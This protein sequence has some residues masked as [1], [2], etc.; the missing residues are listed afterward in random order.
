MSLLVLGLPWPGASSPPLQDGVTTAPPAD[1][2]AAVDLLRGLTADTVLVVP[3]Q[4]GPAASRRLHRARKLVGRTDVAV[5]ERRRPISRLAMAARLVT[6]AQAFWPAEQSEAMA[7]VDACLRTTAL[8]HSVGRLEDPAPSLAQHALSAAP[9]IRFLADL[10]AGTVRRVGG[11]WPTGPA[12]SSGTGGTATACASRSAP[13][14]W[15]EELVTRFAP[16]RFDAVPPSDGPEGRFWGT[17]RWAELTVLRRPEQDVLVELRE[18]IAGVPCPSCRRPAA[19]TACVFCGVALRQPDAA[20]HRPV[21]VAA[22]AA[23]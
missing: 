6:Q 21:V 1:D 10:D 16:E 8:L 18:T 19:G 12:S 9:G 17:A 2:L 4:A 3:G 13:T 7:T 22:G 23:S 15:S 14:S 5:V 11:G 20:S